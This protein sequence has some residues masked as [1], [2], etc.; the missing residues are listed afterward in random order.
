[1][2][3]RLASGLLCAA[4]ATCFFAEAASAKEQP[5]NRRVEFEC[6]D[7]NTRC[8]GDID[9]PKSDR[10]TINFVSC[11]LTYSGE[12]R[13]QLNITRADEESGF[14][15]LMTPTGTNIKIIS[16][17]VSIY[18]PRSAGSFLVFSVHSGQIQQPPS[19][20]VSGFHD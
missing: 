10:T 1:M 7:G 13:P 19:C 4:I 18:V 6:K 2:I 14:F 16:Q 12:L 15:I 9:V 3:V 20:V 11:W 17:T 8:T 5:F